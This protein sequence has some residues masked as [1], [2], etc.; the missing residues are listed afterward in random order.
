MSRQNT[1]SSAGGFTCSGAGVAVAR[2]FYGSSQY[3]SA[4]QKIGKALRETELE[5]G[6]TRPPDAVIS[7]ITAIV[8]EVSKRNALP[9]EADVSVFFGEA[10]VTWRCAKREI[11]LLS[12]GNSDDPKILQYEA[13]QA[14]PSRHQVVANATPKN[15]KD[16]LGWLYA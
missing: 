2:A 15:L 1:I 6:E 14:E 7:G 5:P 4:A 13:G 11:S 8:D 9:A 3:F 16:A 12:K 10:L